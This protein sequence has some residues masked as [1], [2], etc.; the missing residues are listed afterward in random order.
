MEDKTL[1]PQAPDDINCSYNKKY[2]SF[3]LN[4]IIIYVGGIFYKQHL[5]T[6]TRA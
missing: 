3:L 4:N 6:G 2:I 1:G 5:E